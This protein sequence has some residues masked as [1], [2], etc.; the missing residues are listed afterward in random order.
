[1]AHEPKTDGLTEKAPASLV[2]AVAVLSL[3]ALHLAAS[4]VGEQA[5]EAQS[6]LARLEPAAAQ[7]EN[8]VL[9]AETL[10]D[11]KAKDLAV[12]KA[13]LTQLTGSRRALYEAGLQLQEEKRQLE[14]LEEVLLTYLRVDKTALKV[15]VMRGDQALLTYPIGYAPKILGEDPRPLP[16][17]VRVVSKERFAHPERGA[18]EQTAGQV[19]W[20]P[21]QVGTSSRASSL[22]EFV[23][24]T[25]GPLI[26]HGPPAN[27]AEH[28]KYP[29]ACVG[30]PLAVARRLYEK[31]FIGT[32]LLID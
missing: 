22:G 26:L 21:P 9:N 11:L 23:V 20:E 15:S 5:G 28:Q 8:A 16:K 24:F 30:L 32:K 17:I 29:H 4:R 12:F 27:P 6:E 7:L 10:R 31:S 1:M 18:Y 3:I 25:D 2:T 14:K 13:G 19:K